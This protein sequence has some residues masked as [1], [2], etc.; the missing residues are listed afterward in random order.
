MTGIVFDIQ[1]FSIHDGPGIRTTVFL[2]GC[3][4]DCAWCH[5]PEGISPRPVLS[6]NT[7]KC[8]FC[9]ECVRVCPRHAHT[10][11]APVHALDRARCETCGRCATACDAGGLELVGRM[12]TV[13]EV[14]REVIADLPCYRHTAGGLTLSG[15][16]PLMQIDFAI[17]LLQRAKQAGIGSVVQTCG[18]TPWSTFERVLPWV[19][20]F[21]YDYKVTDPDAHR[22]FTG[23]SNDIILSNLRRVY[24]AGAHIRL[25]CPLIPGYN[26]TEDHLTGIQ[27]LAAEMPRLEGISILPYHRL[28]VDKRARLGLPFRAAVKDDPD[29]RGAAADWTRRIAVSLGSL[30]APEGAKVSR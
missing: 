5:N 25:Q 18:F 19:D 29:A 14:M 28:G 26:D 3:P 17:A 13:D 4:L 16:E 2:Q 22:R 1:R 11:E 15:G 12:V 21:L 6:L 23:R 7:E 20:L 9:G 30:L 8:A 27:M 10:V 24:A